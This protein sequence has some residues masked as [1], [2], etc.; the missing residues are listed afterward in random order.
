MMRGIMSIP[1]TH[2]T[3]ASALAGGYMS[4]IQLKDRRFEL[5]KAFSHALI[6]S[7]YVREP[8]TMA[9]EAIGYAD[10]LLAALETE[11]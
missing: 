6:S 2:Y 1:T 8:K 4:T 3:D 9:E 10:A 7:G 5:A 11:K